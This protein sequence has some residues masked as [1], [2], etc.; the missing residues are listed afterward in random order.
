ML[1]KLTTLKLSPKQRD[2]F[3]QDNL[4]IKQED[5]PIQDNVKQE[6]LDV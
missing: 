3:L 1:G 6:P 2:Y 4:Q 5:L